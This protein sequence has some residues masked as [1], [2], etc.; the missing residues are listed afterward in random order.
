MN[1]KK[2]PHLN[3]F[4]RG[5]LLIL[6][7]LA[8]VRYVFPDVMQR[9][10][11]T[12]EDKVDEY[13]VQVVSEPSESEAPTMADAFNA[14]SAEEEIEGTD[15]QYDSDFDLAE[16]ETETPENESI[17]TEDVISPNVQSVSSSV[18]LLPLHQTATFFRKKNRIYSVPGSYIANF[19]DVQDV[20]YPSA[21]RWGIRPMSNRDEFEKYRD[22]LVYVG[23]NPYI[24][25]DERMSSSIPYLVPRAS[26][27]LEY[28]GRAFLDS[29]YSKRIPL[30]KFVV[31]SVLRTEA[32]VARLSRGGNVNATQRSCHMFGTTFDISY[33]HYY[34]V[35]SP[36]GPSRRAVRDD[37]LKMV[38][39]EVLRDARNQGRC[40]VRYEVKQPCFHIT[41]R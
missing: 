29:L 5:C 3:R 7:I 2:L 35:S 27:L 37:S 26:E 39:G 20:Q 14:D 25:L 38:L 15:E 40:Y 31:S 36:D 12:P 33:N 1:L 10:D 8:V 6:C 13:V 22:K 28:L 4:Y 41:V 16:G 34:T 23:S 24:H 9:T 11:D 21:S 30:H 17:K 18:E 19:P 32:D